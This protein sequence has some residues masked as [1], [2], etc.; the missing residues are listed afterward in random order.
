MEILLEFPI[1]ANIKFHTL[2][3]ATRSSVFLIFTPLSRPMLSA[4]IVISCENSIVFTEENSSKSESKKYICIARVQ[5]KVKQII[6]CEYE[7]SKKKNQRVLNRERK[8][9]NEYLQLKLKKKKQQITFSVQHRQK[10]IHQFFECEFCR[11]AIAKETPENIP[12]PIN[13]V[14]VCVSVHRCFL[15]P[16]NRTRAIWQSQK[17][18]RTRQFEI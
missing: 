3:P 1:F 4:A 8:Q 11:P 12:R 9:N 14:C 16:S 7:R 15:S 10:K 13:A 5:A 18:Q 2:S 6:L 17:K